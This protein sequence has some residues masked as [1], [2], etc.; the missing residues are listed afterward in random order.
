[1]T[2][3]APATYSFDNLHLL[4]RHVAPGESG[5]TFLTMLRL[6]DLK[7][8]HLYRNYSIRVN[9]NSGLHADVRSNSV[10]FNGSPVGAVEMFVQCT[11]HKLDALMKPVILS[12]LGFNFMHI[13]T[14]QQ[15]TLGLGDFIVLFKAG[16]TPDTVI[17]MTDR[18]MQAD[19]DLAGPTIAKSFAGLVKTFRRNYSYDLRIDYA[20]YVLYIQSCIDEN[21][22]VSEALEG[23][24]SPLLVSPN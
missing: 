1:M 6:R 12:D 11:S 7:F 3:S 10:S 19:W 15:V 9:V 24:V 13:P 14:E 20:L 2:A 18:S 4:N 21:F 22:V 5:A 8:Q 23:V 16:V 17:I